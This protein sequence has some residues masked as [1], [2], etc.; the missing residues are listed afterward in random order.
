MEAQDPMEYNVI[1]TNHVVNDRGE[2]VPIV[3]FTDTRR[4]SGEVSNN[5]LIR[6]EG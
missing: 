3:R 4:T 5:D 2:M 1:I 6:Y